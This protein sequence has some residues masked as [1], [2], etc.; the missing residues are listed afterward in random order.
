[1]KVL[2]LIPWGLIDDI[3]VTTNYEKLAEVIVGGNAEGQNN[4]TAQVKC[5]L[6]NKSD[7][8]SRKKRKWNQNLTLKKKVMQAERSKYA[9][10]R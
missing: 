1:M 5:M 8:E 4:L 3:V 10:G 2:G 9:H 7:R 6:H